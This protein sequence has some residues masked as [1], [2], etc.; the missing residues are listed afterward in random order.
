M[1]SMCGILATPTPGLILD[2]SLCQHRGPNQT[3]RAMHS[4]WTLIFHRLAITG[5]KEG[6]APVTSESGRWLVVLNGEIV[7]FRSLQTS[8]ALRPSSSDTQAIADG[9]QKVGLRFLNSLRG[10]YAG[11]VIDQKRGQVFAF[12]DPL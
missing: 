4:G 1:G 9:I 3:Y 12:R 6:N 5:G 2:E 10:M 11:L 8:Y 7:N